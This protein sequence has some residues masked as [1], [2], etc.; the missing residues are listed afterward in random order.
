[1]N[2]LS[3]GMIGVGWPCFGSIVNRFKVV[4]QTM[5]HAGSLLERRSRKDESKNNESE[6]KQ[7]T[8]ASLIDT[9]DEH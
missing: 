1:M 3:S 6:E 2:W 7:D 5:S 9:E 4:I 8:R